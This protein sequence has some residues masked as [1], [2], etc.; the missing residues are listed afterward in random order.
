MRKKNYFLHQKPP[1]KYFGEGLIQGGRNQFKPVIFCCGY[2]SSVCWG[3]KVYFTAF[4]EVLFLCN[5]FSLKDWSNTYCLPTKQ[6]KWEWVQIKT[7]LVVFFKGK[8]IND[9]SKC[10]NHKLIG[11]ST[12]CLV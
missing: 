9:C 4:Y 3:H 11:E 12:F 8:L 1:G 7:L 5:Q 6:R 10:K 2:N